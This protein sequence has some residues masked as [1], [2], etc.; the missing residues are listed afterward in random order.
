LEIAT[1]AV[2][3]FPHPGWCVIS[4]NCFTLL[5]VW[6]GSGDYAYTF[7]HAYVILLWLSAQSIIYQT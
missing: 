7:V 6:G 4:V 2:Y 3:G 5:V 1:F